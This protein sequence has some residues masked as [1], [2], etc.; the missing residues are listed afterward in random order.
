MPETFKKNECACK[1]CMTYKMN[2]INGEFKYPPGSIPPPLS[3]E[4]Q[5][6]QD[7]GFDRSV[8]FM[9]GQPRQT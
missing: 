4:D 5:P 7:K 9:P 6:T 3:P 2:E 8:Y 1:E